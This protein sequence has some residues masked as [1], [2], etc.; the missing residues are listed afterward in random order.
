[1]PQSLKDKKYE[2]SPMEKTFGSASVAA[3]VL[4]AEILT[5]LAPVANNRGTNCTRHHEGL[6]NSCNISVL[7]NS[8]VH[9]A[10]N[11]KLK[12]S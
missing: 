6:Q 5:A 8:K 1:M 11:P 7:V 9:H 2:G 10:S 4:L 12:M 3:H